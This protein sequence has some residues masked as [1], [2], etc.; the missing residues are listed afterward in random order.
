MERFLQSFSW[1]IQAQNQLI[2]GAVLEMSHRSPVRVSILHMLPQLFD[3]REGPLAAAYQRAGLDY[4]LSNGIITRAQALTV[5]N[6][7]ARLLGVDAF[8][9][10]CASAADPARLGL[11][12]LALTSGLT[13][14][15]CLQNLSRALPAFEAGATTILSVRGD[16]ASLSHHLSGGDPNAAGFLYE[17][18]AAFLVQA[19][20]RL[21]GPGWR[22]TLVLFP[23]RPP[24]RVQPFEEFFG[25]PVRFEAAQTSIIR[26]PAAQLDKRV[27]SLQSNEA[28]MWEQLQ[29]GVREMA[30]FELAGELL[31]GSCENIID[32]M[33]MSG[34]VSL[35]AAARTLGLSA[36]SMQRQLSALETSFEELTER[37]RRQKAV[38]LLG[39][40]NL[41]VAEVA[42]ALGYSDS[43]HFIRA[44]RRWYGE[45]PAQFSLRSRMS[46]RF[47]G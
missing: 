27:S 47:F 21:M 14:R 8:S 38:E 15:Q 17:G 41:R 13:L 26:F 19:I 32:C 44:F 11:L 29:L 16:E 1:R 4:S 6:Y 33:M 30:S 34:K 43:A 20:R 28:L 23:H 2:I 39:N 31:V 18:V 22:P 36:R 9:L 40:P 24:P 46:A 12:G 10:T 25:A 3:Q 42:I 7:S 37:R 5:F 45:P 35:P